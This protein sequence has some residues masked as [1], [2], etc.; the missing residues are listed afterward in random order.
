M[1]GMPAQQPSSPAHAI[2]AQVRTLP[3]HAHALLEHAARVHP[4]ST[5]TSLSLAGDPERLRYVELI[6][7]ARERS[8]ELLA[9]GLVPGDRVASVGSSSNQQMAWLYGAL[10]AG[11]CTHLLNPQHGTHALSRQLALARPRLILHD[12]GLSLPGDDALPP[13]IPTRSMDE[14]SS[15]PGADRGT[16]L[17][18]AFPE[19]SASHVC[20]SSGTTGAPK[21]IQYTHRSTV[22]HAWACVLPDAMG[23]RADDRVMSLVQMYQASA[24]GAPFACPLV[25]ASL[26]LAPPSRDPARWFDWIEAHGVT[27]LGAVSAH[28]LVLFRYMQAHGLRFTTLRCSV[29]GGTRLPTALAELISRVLGI[30]I[31]HAWGMTETSPL[32]SIEHYRPEQGALLHGKPMFGIELALHAPG[33]AGS[34]DAPA[35]L[36]VRGHWVAQRGEGEWLDTGD[37]AR[38]RDDGRLEVID[39]L[40]ESIAASGPVISCAEV[41]FRACSVPGVGDAALLGSHGD[42][43]MSTTLAWTGAP[44]MAVDG[45]A[46]ERLLLRQ[47]ARCFDGWTPDHC[48]RVEAFPY[49]PSAKVR[50]HVLRAL[51]GLQAAQPPGASALPAARNA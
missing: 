21:S 32:A 12:P 23:L 40:D 3:L 41:E 37:L 36:R 10:A 24:W 22:L 19:D 38:L 49:T 9:A 1:G 13:D 14:A 18:S 15:W 46:V 17:P 20:Y 29:V 47:I 51:L 28:W 7:L 16:S 50:K 31:L 39:R 43:R 6:E 44:G 30:R 35:E 26:V 48:V 2:D 33:A 5:V 25:G 42:G 11:V 45:D 4:D 34:P 8:R 27:V